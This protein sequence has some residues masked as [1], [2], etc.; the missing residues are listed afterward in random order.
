MVSIKILKNISSSVWVFFLCGMAL[1]LK[2]QHY[3][4]ISSAKA[5]QNY[6]AYKAG[7]KVILSGHRGG[8]LKGFPENSIETFENTLANY[9]AFFEID[10]RLTKDSVVVLMHD[11]TL[12]RTTNGTGKLADYTYEEIKKLRLKDV[13]GNLTDAKI[14]TLKEAILWSKGKTVL[15]LDHKNVPLELT[16][17]I[18]EECKNDIIMLTVHNAKQ[19][20]FYLDRNPNWMLSA[21]VLTKKSFYEYHDAKIDWNRIIAYIGPKFTPEN[22]ELLKLLNDRKVSCMISAA[23]SADKLPIEER[24]SVYKAIV[25][26]GANILETDRPIEVGGTILLNRKNLIN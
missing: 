22:E 9:P 2:A 11:A 8:M 7:K 13:E 14:P 23:P 19:A 21:H 4:K 15:N 1:N 17:K 26:K 18:L 16:A 25:E 24:K 20:K 6:F 3:I 5:M 10:P 12:D